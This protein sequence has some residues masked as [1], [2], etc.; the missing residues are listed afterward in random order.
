MG[1]KEERQAKTL[2]LPTQNLTNIL[3]RN[4]LNITEIER[5]SREGS[6]YQ[7]MVQQDGST[8]KKDGP[9]LDRNMDRTQGANLDLQWRCYIQ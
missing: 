4:K 9:L 3:E 7:Q 8:W 1:E 5:T 6:T 2:D